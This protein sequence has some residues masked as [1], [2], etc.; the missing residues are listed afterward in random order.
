M[1]VKGSYTLEETSVW[2]LHTALECP[3]KEH[4]LIDD[5][6]LNFCK[7]GS[8]LVLLF[9]ENSKRFK[10]EFSFEKRLIQG[11]VLHVYSAQY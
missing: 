10:F 1:C 11:P 7:K 2:R 3:D 5:W 8:V 4:I 9:Y 6:L